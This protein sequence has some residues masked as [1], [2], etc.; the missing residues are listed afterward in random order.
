MPVEL[1][2][3]AEDYARYCK[4]FPGELFARLARTDNGTRGQ[5]VLDVRAGTGLFGSELA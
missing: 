1:K 5:H 3:A 2:P 4:P